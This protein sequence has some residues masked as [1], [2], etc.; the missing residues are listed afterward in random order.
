MHN[1]QPASLHFIEMVHLPSLL[2]P[3][4]HAFYSHLICQEEE[5]EEEEEKL[6][7]AS[8]Q[9]MALLSGAADRR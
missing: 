4:H 5:E 3:L 8:F 2:P 9:C 7:W 6:A 1:F